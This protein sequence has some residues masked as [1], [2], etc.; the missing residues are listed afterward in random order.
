MLEAFP[1]GARG[2]G[3]RS[4]RGTEGAPKSGAGCGRPGGA[5]HA[6]SLYPG[7]L[8]TGPGA[9]GPLPHSRPAGPGGLCGSALCAL[10]NALRELAG[11]RNLASLGRLRFDFSSQSVSSPAGALAAPHEAQGLRDPGSQGT[12]LAQPSPCAEP[13]PLCGRSASFRSA[14]LRSCSP[15][16]GWAGAPRTLSG[17]QP[18]LPPLGF[19]REIPAPTPDSKITPSPLAGPSAPP[20]CFAFDQ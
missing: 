10:A 13:R 7:A 1:R 8:R 4:R 17:D 12:H 11:L 19:P 20:P 2:G 9:Q 15:A 5:L 14:T 18:Q 16:Q 6:P 3:H